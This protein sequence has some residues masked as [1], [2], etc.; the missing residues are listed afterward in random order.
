LDDFDTEEVLTRLASVSLCD[1]DLRTAHVRMHDVMRAYFAARLGPAARD[2]HARLLAAWPDPLRLPH[3]YAWRWFAYHLAAVGQEARLRDLVLDPAWL[4]AKVDATDVYALGADLR[5]VSSDP[6]VTVLRRGLRL[7]SH[8]LAKDKSQLAPQL[9]ARLP[10]SEAQYRERLVRLMNDRGVG[11]LRPLVQSLTGPGGALLR[12]F[13]CPS[14]P[15]TLAVM[16]EGD[17]IAVGTTDGAITCWEIEEGT[18]VWSWQPPADDIAPMTRA[19][20]TGG[21]TIA[22]LH[23]G[24]LVLGGPRGVAVWDPRRDSEP[25]QAV[26]I[27]EGVSALAVSADGTGVLAGSSKGT[28]CLCSLETGEEIHRLT[29][30]R[31]GVASVAMSADGTKAVSGG[32]DKAVR[33]WDL[34]N[35]TLVDALHPPHD[36]HVYAVA[37]SMDGRFAVSGSADRT[38]RVWDLRSGMLRET[39]SGH[40][41]RV[42]AVAISRNGKLVVSGSHDREVAVWDWLSGLVQRTFEGHA[43]AV[44][45]RS[46]HARRAIR[47]LGRTRPDRSRVAARCESCARVHTGARQRYPCGQRDARWSA[48]RYRWTGSHGAIVGRAATTRHARASRA[49]RHGGSRGFSTRR[50]GR[51][52]PARTIGRSPSG[53]RTIPCLS[54]PFRD[55]LT[56]SRR[57]RFRRTALACSRHRWMATSFCGTCS[58]AASSGVG[59]PTGA[60]SPSSRQPLT[61]R[62]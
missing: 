4:Q 38:I 33:L 43:D 26:R 34:A 41:H 7:S 2:V 61:G 51:C 1:F 23:D 48:R 40:R 3:S 15:A 10:E 44:G 47:R 57:C 42:Y 24:R 16:L 13:T 53:T 37:I 29:G 31:L 8:V 17:R 60:A 62:S 21:F 22:A 11:W 27:Q 52:S 39:L 14:R 30:H 45:V 35:G 19:A 54:A 5:R 28:L 25:T 32:Y 56:E 18:L 36:G 12:T 49:S 58:V 50:P 55:T 46:V 20:E 6:F 9:L 59:T